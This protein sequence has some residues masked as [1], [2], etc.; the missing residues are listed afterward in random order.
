MPDVTVSFSDAQWAR[1]I[2]ASSSIKKMDEAGVVDAAYLAAKWTT[3]LGKWVKE[4]ERAKAAESV[5][6]F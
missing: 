4:T 6:D 5:D 2:A 1:I 3:Q